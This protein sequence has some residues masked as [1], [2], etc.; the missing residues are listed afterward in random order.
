MSPTSEEAA[1]AEFLASLDR[2]F[3]VLTLVVSIPT[4]EQVAAGEP[5]L[6][7]A[8]DGAWPT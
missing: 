7:R 6:F 4:S 1:H 2:S 3:D 5:T 8:A